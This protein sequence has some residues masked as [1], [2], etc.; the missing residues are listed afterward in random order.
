MKNNQLTHDENLITHTAFFRAH[1]Y[2]KPNVR[3][4]CFPAIAKLENSPE[5]RI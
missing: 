1:H 5:K 2:N 4:V 3:P